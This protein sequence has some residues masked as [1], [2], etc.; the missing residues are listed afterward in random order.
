M[1]RPSRISVEVTGETGAVEQVRV[2]GASVVV[3]KGE[4][5]V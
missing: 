1:K 4:V 2:G 3:A 5:F